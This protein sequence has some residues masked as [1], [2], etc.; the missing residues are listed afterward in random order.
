MVAAEGGGPV[1]FELLGSFGIRAGGSRIEL[2]GRTARAVLVALLL[3]PEGYA[4]A[5]QLIAA[6]WSG[7][8]GP[9]PGV[10]SLYRYISQLRGW[11]RPLG[12]AIDRGPNGAHY[13]LAV[14]AGAVDAARFAGLAGSATALAGT[15]PEEA[16]RRLRA[17]LALWRGPYAVPEL[18]PRRVE[19]LARQLDRARL[20]AEELRA[21]LELR[22]GQP[23][24]LPETLADL[25]AAHPEHDGVTAALIRVL[26]AAGRTGEAEQVYHHAVA[27]RGQ[28]VPPKLDQARRAPT[29]AH[30]TAPPGNPRPEELPRVSPYFAGRDQELDWLLGARTQTPGAALVLALNGMAGIG[31]TELALQAARRMLEA[32]RFPDGAIYL[33]LH[34]ASALTP[35]SPP[36]ALEALLR[37]LGVSGTQVPGELDARANLYRTR[38]ARRRV[39][40]VLDDAW[41][42]TQVRP[43]LPGTA[44]SLVLVTSRRRLVALD[45][46]EQLTLDTLG[47]PAAV[48]LL[49]AMILPRGLEDDRTA[50]SIV[51]LCGQLPLAIRIVAARLRSSRALTGERVLAQLQA[52]RGRLPA[53]DDGARSIQATLTMSYQH[54][55]TSQQAALALLSLHP[56]PDL[57]P[58]AAAALLGGQPEQAQQVLGVLTRMNLLDEPAEGR[59]RFPDLIHEY[60][61]DLPLTADGTA[62]L[63]RLYDHYAARTGAAAAAG[64]PYET[65]CPDAGGS[66]AALAWLDAELPSLLAT[67]HHAAAHGR[68]DHL[69]HQS[70][71]LH[72]HLRTR[73]RYS[74]AYAL[75]ARALD[76]AAPGSAAEREARTALGSIYRLQGRYDLALTCLSRAAEM[77][78]AAGD[79]A[80]QAT[81]LAA[82]GDTQAACGEQG[83]AGASYS[84]AL[85]LAHAAH[86]PAAQVDAYNGLGAIRLRQDRPRAAEGSYRQALALA[87][88]CGYVPG[89]I[90]SRAGLAYAWLAGDRPD[91]ALAGYRDVLRVAR[92][93]GNRS[94]QLNALSGLGRVNAHLGR[95]HQATEEYGRVLDLARATGDL[96]AEIVALTGLGDVYRRQRDHRSAIESY[97]QAAELAD[98]SGAPNEQFEAQLGLGRMHYAAGDFHRASQA[99]HRALT[100]AKQLRQRTDEIRALD[101]LA[102]GHHA[103][104]R[105]AQARQLWRHALAILDELGAPTAL[106]VTAAEIRVKLLAAEDTARPSTQR[107]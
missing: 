38:V 74:D 16:L 86:L 82:L 96:A 27:A 52:E 93:S 67:A 88:R 63:D 59:H 101:G 98:A 54:L 95:Y 25:V 5:G 8:A 4:E 65:G 70:R 9:A 99:H 33:D 104:G 80:A 23:D 19:G 64:Y 90:N 97:R 49:R 91:R 32:G 53:L 34:G 47:V 37:S 60:A 77:A 107:S 58:E 13:H 42:E 31:K 15:E 20:D 51:R 2:G 103:Q 26:R 55:T 30:P 81:A 50:E 100:L 79:G 102:D 46:A 12:L 76:A 94:G 71:W 69:R 17:A 105:L 10:D 73:G 106:D 72:R 43:L 39:V 28:H 40:I 45:D 1:R 6:V 14:P 22:H 35:M 36:A 57:E 84:R 48:R 21:D 68:P 78:A 87:V 56:G 89:E 75:H 66:E 24:S 41:D 29:A 44:N 61:A 3:R 18:R 11:L 62:P 92:E 7:A 83:A 85:R